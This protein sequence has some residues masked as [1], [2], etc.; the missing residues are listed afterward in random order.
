M[1]VFFVR[2]LRERR[3]REGQGTPLKPRQGRLPLDPAGQNL[4]LKDTPR[5]GKGTPSPRRRLRP[6]TP[7]YGVLTS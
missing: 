7:L 3:E 4:N 2:S 6:P 5:P 1:E